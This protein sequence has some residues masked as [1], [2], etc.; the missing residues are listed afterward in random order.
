M[1]V[2]KEHWENVYATKQPHEVSWTQDYP[3][4][5]LDLIHRLNLPKTARIIDAGGGDSRLVDCLLDEGFKDITVLDISKG[6]LE[7]AQQRLGSKAEH[8]TWIA[9]DILDFKP[10]A[11]YDLWHDRALFHF[12]RDATDIE[13]YRVIVNQWVRRYL[14]LA[15]F[16]E[17]GPKRCSGLDV[18]QYSEEALETQFAGS[19]KKLHCIAEDHTTPFS[20]KQNFLFCSFEHIPLPAV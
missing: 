15:T 3:N 18:H 6:A 12:F 14:V 10:S 5:S 11:P 7:R 17:Q 8:V 9:S 2:R 16:S 19:F 13:Q 1:E 4:I 20:T